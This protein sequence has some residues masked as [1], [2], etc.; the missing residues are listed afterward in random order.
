MAK[1]KK[2][3]KNYF[4]KVIFLFILT[5]VFASP[6]EIARAQAVKCFIPHGSKCLIPCDGTETAIINGKTVVVGC[7]FN[8]FVQLGQNLIN[9][10]IVLSIPLTAIAFAWA[11]FLMVTS[12][13]SEEKIKQGKAI[14]GKV[15]VGFIFILGA[16]LIV[17]TITTALLN[18]PKN[19]SLLE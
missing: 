5:L 14:F 17:Y 15:L 3:N 8:D 16:W 9:F 7:Q 2:T 13:G 10:L 1:E 4:G 18:D 11:G 19:Y 12:A 6:F